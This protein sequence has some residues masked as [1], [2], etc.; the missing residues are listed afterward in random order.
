MTNTATIVLV[1]GAW[2]GD[3]AYWKLTPCLEARGV[4]WVGADL[5]SCRAT[6]ASIDIR[7]DAAYVRELIDAVDGRVVVVGKSYGGAVIGGAAVDHPSVAHLVYVAA[8]M[9]AAG[10]PFMHAIGTARTPEFARGIKLLEDGRT[11]MDPE[12]GALTGFTHASEED[13]DVWRRNRS[14][15]SMGRDPS[16]AFDRL[17]WETIPST[18]VICA[19]DKAIDPRAQR[20]WARQATHQVEKPFDHSPAVSHPDEVADL[21]TGITRSQGTVE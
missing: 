9:P 18:Y 4:R 8:I 5:P 15:M 21:L 2:C 19:A 13:R 10:Q 20:A 1:H 3:W 6:D 17:A 14:P 12:I 7:D 16:V 11:E